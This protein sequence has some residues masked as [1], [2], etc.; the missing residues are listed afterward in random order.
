[1]SE[2]QQILRKHLN[3]QQFLYWLNHLSYLIKKYVY[4]LERDFL[5]L[6]LRN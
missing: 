6:V 1:M 3:I 2:P 5:F 4:I